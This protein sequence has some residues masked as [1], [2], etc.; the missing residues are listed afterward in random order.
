MSSKKSSSLASLYRP[1]FSKM[2]AD[3]SGFID[4][5]ELFTAISELFPGVAFTMKDISEM[6]DE[7]DVDHDGVI[8]LEEFLEVMTE[9]KST[10]WGQAQKSMWGRF[11][12]NTLETVS[13]VHTAAEPLKQIARTHS[14][15]RGD[16]Q[17]ASVGLR[18]G[19][20]IVAV[21]VLVIVF[22]FVLSLSAVLKPILFLAVCLLVYPVIFL[23]NLVCFFKGQDLPMSLMDLQMVHAETGKPFGF[24]LFLIAQILFHFLSWIEVVMLPCTG[25]TLTQRIMGAEIVVIQR[26]L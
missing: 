1:M 2:D 22:I 25:K 19:A 14:Y 10:L 11:S 23:A 26:K 16:L 3:K 6:M 13:V 8:S 18:I 9:G 21:V 24:I 12:A 15:R 17:I 5:M 20:T 4:S 7:A